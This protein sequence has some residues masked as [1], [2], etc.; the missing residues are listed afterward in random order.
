DHFEP[1]RLH[2]RQVARL[3]ALENAAGIYA[4][5][6]IGTPYAC[7]RTT[8][9]PVSHRLARFVDRRQGI[10]CREGNERASTV[11]K[12]RIVQ[13]YPG[14]NMYGLRRYKRRFQFPLVRKTEKQY[15]RPSA[16]Y[17][18]SRGRPINPIMTCF[19]TSCAANSRRF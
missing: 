8:Q 14:A 16:A 18:G 17:L 6:T 12:E 7:A 2:H 9:P 11:D 3:L 15:F 19:G 4:N 5:L 13:R 10:A 1:A